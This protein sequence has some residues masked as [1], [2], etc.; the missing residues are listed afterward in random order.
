MDRV[1]ALLRE[2]RAGLRRLVTGPATLERTLALTLGGLV[3]AAIL[4]LALSAIGLLRKQAEQ[5]SLARVQLAGVTARE[6]S[7]AE[8]RFSLASIAS[9]EDA[10]SLRSAASRTPS[11][12]SSEP[13]ARASS[14]WKRRTWRRIALAARANPR[15][16]SS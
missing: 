1:S 5:H 2:W 12:A 6:E 15:V 13:P 4:I 8:S 11:R 3:L 14:S 10:T 16:S 9:S 7:Q